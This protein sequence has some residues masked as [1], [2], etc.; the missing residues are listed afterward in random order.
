MVD[1]RVEKRAIQQSGINVGQR[2]LALGACQ[3][4]CAVSVLAMPRAKANARVAAGVN[5][6]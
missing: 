2:C 4:G 1:P 3:L 6:S 5:Q